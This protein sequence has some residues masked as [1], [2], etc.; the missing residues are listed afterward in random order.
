MVHTLDGSGATVVSYYYLRAGDTVA[1]S[2]ETYD[3]TAGTI[4]TSTVENSHF[5]LVWLGE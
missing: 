2:V 5:E 4:A 3:S 1:P